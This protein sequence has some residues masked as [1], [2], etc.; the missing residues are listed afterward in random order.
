MARAK[1]AAT[2]LARH[3]LP[4]GLV[5]VFL[6]TL[7]LTALREELIEVGY[8]VVA[9]VDEEARLREERDQAI[10]RVQELKNPARL[11]ALANQNGFVRPDHTIDLR[12][13]RDRSTVAELFAEIRPIRGASR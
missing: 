1:P 12:A 3:W 11:S 13:L 4:A 2:H 6:A 7:A 10:A 5:G 8:E 9:A